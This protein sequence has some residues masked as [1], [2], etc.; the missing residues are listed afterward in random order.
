MAKDMSKEERMWGAFCHLGGFGMVVPILGNIAAP[1][2]LWMVKR[3]DSRFVD[4][5][6]KEAVDF[7]ITVSIVA[8]PLLLLSWLVWIGFLVL[9]AAVALYD[10]VMITIASVRSHEGQDFA[11]PLAF[12]FI[13]HEAGP[14]APAKP[15]PAPAPVK[16]APEEPKPAPKKAAKKKASKKKAAKK[17]SRR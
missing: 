16:Q 13:R 5:Q 8:L 2:I 9:L 17:K 12:R 10:L 15:A 11:Y 4:A 6:G 3:E 7:Q 1:L 14:A